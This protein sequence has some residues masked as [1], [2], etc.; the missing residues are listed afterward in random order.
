MASDANID[1]AALI[2]PISGDLPTGPDMRGDASPTSN[3]QRIKSERAMAR[4]AER[5][6]VHDGDTTKADE[7]WRNIVAL[8]PEIL[9]YDSKDLEV[10]CW[11]A[12]AMLRRKG[13]SGLRDVFA[14]IEGLI[15]QHW[16]TLHP[17]PDEDG[18]ET[19]IACLAGLNGEGAE[20]AL[21][22]PLRKVEITQGDSPFS[23][24]QYKQAL[25]TLKGADEETKQRKIASLG[26]SMEDVESA[27]TDS[28][29][30]FFVD[31]RDDLTTCIETYRRIGQT[32]DELCGLHEAPP[33][34]LIVEV[35]EECLGAVNHIAV[36]KFPTENLEEDEAPAESDAPDND[37][38]KS[39]ATNQ[40]NGPIQ[41]REAAFKKL[42]E[43]A[44]F[45]KKTE[46]HSPVSYMLQRAVKWGNMPLEE[47]IGELISDE[48]SRERYSELTGV[49]TSED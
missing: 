38:K 45:F 11:Y 37:N 2:A 13:F 39:V 47:L 36:H 26:F 5:Q 15:N 29:E 49:K 21:L 18:M 42:L 10:S 7:H 44:D 41:S 4:S 43:I 6:S 28:S 32:L 31:I 23:L 34:R 12:E 19:R 9:Q 3:Y 16:D 33:T 46:P 40:N 35:L 30:T 48:S 1:I 20:G 17:M 14:V 8:A 24:W 27:V 22:S 25:E